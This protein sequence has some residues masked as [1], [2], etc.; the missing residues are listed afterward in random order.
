MTY[1]VLVLPYLEHMPTLADTPIALGEGAAIAG[2]CT[3]GKRAYFGALATIR[4]DGHFV[5]VGDDFWFGARSTIHIAHERLPAVVGNNVTVGMNATVH[6]CEVKDHCVIEDHVVVLDGAIVGEGCWIAPGSV[7]FGKHEMPA[8][9]YCEGSPAKPVRTI[10]P[11]QREA[12]RAR[13]RALSRITRIQCLAP[14]SISVGHTNYVAPTARVRGDV[15]L[16]EEVSVWFGCELIAE[17]APLS[18]GSGTNIQ[19][20]TIVIADKHGVTIGTNV[21]VGHNVTMHDCAVGND[22]LVGIGSV[23]APGTVIESGV[24]LA[25]GSITLPG[26]RLSEGSMWAGR[27][28]RRLGPLDDAKRN[29]IHFGAE[30]YRAYNHDYLGGTAKR[31]AHR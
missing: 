31:T 29:I 9:H 28:A 4:A 5:T 14:K 27:P 30:H 6:A 20:N 10:T 19:D 23:V 24:L 22:C 1:T 26:Q 3:V 12:A 18:V 21:T 7:V 8:G 25:A 17:N 11:E 2:R 15:T 13:V 16:A